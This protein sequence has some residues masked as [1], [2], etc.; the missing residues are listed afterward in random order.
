M[1]TQHIMLKD[2]KAVT[3]G[4]GTDYAS[5]QTACYEMD[6]AHPAISGSLREVEK[7]I[8]GERRAERVER[9]QESLKT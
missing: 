9:Y 6:G 2:T 5:G 3:L 1:G 8:P 7:L 4:G